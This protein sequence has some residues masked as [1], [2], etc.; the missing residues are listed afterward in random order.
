MLDLNI[1]CPA[2]KIY[3]KNVGGGLLRDPAKIKL[4]TKFM[5]ERWDGV[6]S[7]KMRI[8]FDSDARFEDLLDAVSAG[9]PDFITI[10]ARTVKQLYRGVPNY[11]AITK[12]V[13]LVDCPVIANGDISSAEKALQ[14]FDRTHCAGVMCGRQAVRNPWIFRQISEA[15]KG[16]E[17][18]RPRLSD[19]RMYI[20]K[21]YQNTLCNNDGM[22]YVDSR[23]KKF[24]NFVGVAVD[25]RG[26]FL[27]NMRRARGVE[28]LF[29]I[30]D[31][32][33]VENGN[34]EKLFGFDAYANL[35]AR[36]NHE[37]KPL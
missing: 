37:D 22:K 16:I 36:P 35:C 14:I 5:R 7:V 2:P 19:V 30:C 33:L 17:I 20:D 18:F 21:L 10:H 26:E 24:I 34:G 29:K 1:G 12:A 23:L 27:Y 13:T 4:L 8:G 31:A 3:K 9:S 15:I 11:D 28:E 6:F 25:E 32:Y